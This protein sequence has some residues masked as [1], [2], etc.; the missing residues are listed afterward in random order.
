MSD[1]QYTVSPI[2]WKAVPREQED[3]SEK[4]LWNK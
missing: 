4:D 1:K 3:Y 2:L